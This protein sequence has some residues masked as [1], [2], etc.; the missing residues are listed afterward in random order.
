MC[1][2]DLDARN[3][4][5][6]FREAMS[7]RNPGIAFK[8]S[9]IMDAISNWNDYFDAYDQAS[10]YQ[11]WKENAILSIKLAE[12]G[13]VTAPGS[14]VPQIYR[15]EASTY[16][17]AIDNGDPPDVIWTNGDAQ[18]S[19]PI[20]DLTSD[21]QATDQDSM[22]ADVPR[23]NASSGGSTDVG[24]P[25][26]DAGSDTPGGCLSCNGISNCLCS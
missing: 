15:W 11:V 6:G 9:T 1:S 4:L 22:T 7:T 3:A 24:A 17:S 14:Q 25:G 12:N 21:P 5:E 8:D 23:L 19:T 2:S 10:S 13:L 16:Q 26:S 18:L 20:T